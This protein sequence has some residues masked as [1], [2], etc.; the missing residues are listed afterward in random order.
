MIEI[1]LVYSL[2]TIF[3][4]LSLSMQSILQSRWNISLKVNPSEKCSKETLSDIKPLG[5][6]PSLVSASLQLFDSFM[7]EW[8]ELPQNSLKP[9]CRL[10][11]CSRVRRVTKIVQKNGKRIILMNKPFSCHW[12]VTL[13]QYINWAGQEDKHVALQHMLYNL[14]YT[15]LHSSVLSHFHKI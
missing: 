3:W 4:C 12:K 5:S 1:Y 8:F 13:L 11:L 10:L 7:V 14:H 9:L 15:D 2:K 6:N